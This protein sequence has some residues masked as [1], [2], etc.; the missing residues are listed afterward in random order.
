M[1]IAVLAHSKKTVGGGLPELRAEL[2]R[3][4]QLDVSWYEVAKSRK[5]PKAARAA[6]AD[7]PDLLLVWGGDGTV[8]RAVDVL[9]RTCESQAPVGVIPAGTSNLFA[10]NLGI[11]HDLAAALDAALGD[12][13]KVIDVGSVNGE[14]FG[15]MAGVGFDAL[16]IGDASRSLKDRLGPRRIRLH[17]REEPAPG[18]GRGTDRHRRRAWF[19]GRA[20]CVVVGNMGELF[21]GIT[22]FPDADPADGTWMSAS[23]RPRSSPT[24]RAWPAERS[25]ATWTA[26]LSSLP[27]RPEESTC[28]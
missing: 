28:G 24:G 17:G 11:P 6:L 14:R 21:G 4:G 2:K 9:A 23:F 16:M 8:Q 15:V 18:V 26:R 3:R 20:S 27:P 22:L 7:G 25:P 12:E 10:G 1:K 13:R 5:V 19:R